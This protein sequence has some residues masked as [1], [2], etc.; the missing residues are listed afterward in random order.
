MA[1]PQDKHY[2]NIL[3]LHS[4][5]TTDQENPVR[6][7]QEEQEVL[8]DKRV[9]GEQDTINCPGVSMPLK[10]LA[11][12]QV[13]YTAGKAWEQASKHGKEPRGDTGVLQKKPEE[14]TDLNFDDQLTLD[15]EDRTMVST[16][17]TSNNINVL[18]SGKATRWV[19]WENKVAQE[20]RSVQEETG[21]MMRMN[22][23]V[24]HKTVNMT[25]TAQKI[26]GIKR[27]DVG[28]EGQEEKV[29]I[30]KKMMDRFGNGK[31]E[32]GMIGASPRPIKKARRRAKPDGMVQQRIDHFLSIEGETFSTTMGGGKHE[33]QVCPEGKLKKSMKKRKLPGR[34]E[35][36]GKKKRI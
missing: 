29:S 31:Q 19:P 35:T 27:T 10:T 33:E 34:V 8:E 5:N 32:G 30:V 12:T 2:N 20:D 23:E 11:I 1:I 36:P 22:V 26:N 24:E 7:I 18:R 16:G 4:T 17:M 28:Y 14:E 15:M 21:H 9:T 25:D 3:N 13:R 6:T